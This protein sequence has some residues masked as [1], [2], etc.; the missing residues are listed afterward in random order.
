MPQLNLYVPERVACLLRDRARRQGV[1]LSK[2]L[3]RLVLGE[4]R[5]AWPRGY[6]DNSVGF[7]Q[8]ELERPSQG[9]LEKRENL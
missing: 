7:W 9:V 2:Y 8:G 4:T 1:S 3:A 6:F 5:D